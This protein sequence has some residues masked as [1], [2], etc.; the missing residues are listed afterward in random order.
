MIG[1]TLY[2]LTRCAVMGSPLERVL[3]KNGTPWATRA[4]CKACEAR[5]VLSYGTA[6]DGLEADPAIF[7]TA[8]RALAEGNSIRATARIVEVDQDTVCTWWH[9]VAC[10]CRAVLLSFWHDLHVS[11]CQLDELW[12]FGHTKEAHLPGAKIYGDT[13]GGRL[14]VDRFCPCLALGPGFVIGKR[15]QAGAHLLLARVAHVTDDA[16][17]ASSA[18]SAC[19]SAGVAAHLRCMVFPTTPGQ[20]GG[21]SQTAAAAA[22]QSAVTHR[23]SNGVRAGAWCSEHR[24]V[25]GTT[26]SRGGAFGPFAVSSDRQHELCRGANVGRK[27]ARL[28]G[29]REVIINLVTQFP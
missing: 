26:G 17:H 15:D 29:N 14:G 16:F 13:Y 19:L 23:S 6:S 4:W 3:V 18:I 12:S 24:V 7:E 25:F 20:P 5:V 8:V 10:H 9:R 27:E 28:P 11:A 22:S 1:K 21:L 2:C